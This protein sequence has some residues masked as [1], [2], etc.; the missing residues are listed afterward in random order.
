LSRKSPDNQSKKDTNSTSSKRW[1]KKEMCKVWEGRE[2]EIEIKSSPTSESNF[3]KPN[4][5][6][7]SIYLYTKGIKGSEGQEGSGGKRE[8]TQVGTPAPRLT[9]GLQE[10]FCKVTFER[11]K[12]KNKNRWI[13]RRG[14]VNRPGLRAAIS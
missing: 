8:G 13:I 5:K 10:K 9:R 11:H 7:P 3:H 12:E 1:T 4:T 2:G 6:N 14:K